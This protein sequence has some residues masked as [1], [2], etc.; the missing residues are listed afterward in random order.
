MLL[1]A[2]GKIRHEVK[3]TQVIYSG[4]ACLTFINSSLKKVG[5]KINAAHFKLG[6]R[7]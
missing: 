2:V 6:F 5:L 3:T 7:S 1:H 4:F